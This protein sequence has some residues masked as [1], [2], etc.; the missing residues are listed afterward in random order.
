MN[1]FKDGDQ[2]Y[3]YDVNYLIVHQ[4]VKRTIN[5]L[6]NDKLVSDNF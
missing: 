2:Y 4:M 6:V 5:W 1:T 3:Y